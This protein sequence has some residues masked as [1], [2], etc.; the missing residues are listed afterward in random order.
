MNSEGDT[1]ILRKTLTEI[2]FDEKMANNG[3]EGFLL[4]IKFYKSANDAALL[5]PVKRNPE[6]KEAVQLEGTAV[7]K[8]EQTTIKNQRCGKFT[9][10]RSV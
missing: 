3:D 8:Q 2:F 1:L 5:V 10:M 7:K 4:T 9:Q 6:G